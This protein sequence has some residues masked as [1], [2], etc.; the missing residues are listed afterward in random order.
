MFR[1]NWV[2]SN[3]AEH[4]TSVMYPTA[5]TTNIVSILIFTR[6]CSHYRVVVAV[7]DNDFVQAQR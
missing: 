5:S 4:N 1:T 7:G 2:V 3:P 6:Y